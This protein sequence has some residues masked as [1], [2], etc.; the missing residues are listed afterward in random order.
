VTTVGLDYQVGVGGKR[1]TK[2]QRQKL[3]IGRALLKQPDLLIVNEAAA[4]MDSA[5][6]LRILSRIRERR[7]GRGIVWTLQR[8]ASA[9]DFD[10]CLVMQAGRLV[11]KGTFEELNAPGSALGELVAAG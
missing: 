11:G 4:V 9:V 6:Q 1:L 5:T 8:A 2:V 7:P 10:Q 3:A